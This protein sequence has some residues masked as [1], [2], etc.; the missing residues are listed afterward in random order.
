MQKTDKKIVASTKKTSKRV[1]KG[2]DY[3]QFVPKIQ[4]RDGKIVPFDFDKIKQAIYKSMTSNEE[5][6][7]AEAE[8]VT[9][10]VVADLVRI[11]K[12]FPNFLPKYSQGKTSPLAATPQTD[13]AQAHLISLLLF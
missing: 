1:S 3:T 9:H 11:G 4:K 12:R 13:L 10:K 6:S 7:L 2:P 5:G 8:L